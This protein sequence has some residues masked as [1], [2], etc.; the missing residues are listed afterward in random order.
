MQLWNITF[1]SL[2]LISIPAAISFLSTSDWPLSE[3]EWTAVMPPYNILNKTEYKGNIQPYQQ[4]DNL[5]EKTGKD[6]FID[7]RWICKRQKLNS[8]YISMT[9]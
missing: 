4:Q 5:H 8:V 2:T 9:L 3:A 6:H 7:K 1:V